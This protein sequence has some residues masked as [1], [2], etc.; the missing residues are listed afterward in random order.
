MKWSVS[1]GPGG[2]LSSSIHRLELTNNGKWV[3]MIPSLSGSLYKFDGESIEPIPITADD[4]LKS[5]FKFSD[6]LVI[7]GGKETRSYGVSVRTGQVLYECTMHGCKNGTEAETA[8]DNF[9]DTH[10]TNNNEIK[11]TSVSEIPDHNALLD[12]VIVVRRSTQTVRA[13][14]PRTGHE[15]WN[16]SIGHHELDMLRSE[17]CRSNAMDAELDKTLLDLELKVIVPEGVI[18]AVRKSTPTVILWK[19][20]V[21]IHIFF[22]YFIFLLIL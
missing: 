16:F 2:L 11:T 4:L 13:V 17:D 22:V 9:N 7:S 12:D 20:K 10:E 3:R 18:C 21:R 14:E 19:H 6:D 15:K 8:T 1:T 5:S